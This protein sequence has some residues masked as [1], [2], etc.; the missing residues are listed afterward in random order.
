MEKPISTGQ[1][2]DGTFKKGFAT[3]PAGKPKGARHKST[4]AAMALLSGEA[5]HY[6]GLHRQSTGRRFDGFKVMFGS[7]NPAVE[8]SP[9]RYHITENRGDIGYAIIH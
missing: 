5:R 7:N 9:Y 1:N 3:N 6:A 8:R 4:L 2:P